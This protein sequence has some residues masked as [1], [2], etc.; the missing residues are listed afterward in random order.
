MFGV[1]FVKLH[2]DVFE[3]VSHPQRKLSHFEVR[4]SRNSCGKQKSRDHTSNNTSQE[5]PC[6]PPVVGY[7]LCLHIRMF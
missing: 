6:L 5:A 4:T 7:F 2:E 3:P 1:W